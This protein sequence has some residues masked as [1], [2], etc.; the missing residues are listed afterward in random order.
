MGVDVQPDASVVLYLEDTIK[1]QLLDQALFSLCLQEIKHLE[2]CIV[3]LIHL[4]EYQE[5]LLMV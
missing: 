2:I 5:E 1:E 3:L 4:P